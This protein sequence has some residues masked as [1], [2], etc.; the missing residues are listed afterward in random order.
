MTDPPV[1][2]LRMAQCSSF[3]LAVFG[4][5]AVGCSS[6]TLREEQ[7]KPTVVDFNSCEVGKLPPDFTTALTG[8]GG[9]VSWVVRKCAGTGGKK[10]NSG[11]GAAINYLCKHWRQL[12]LF[13]QKA[14]VPQII[15]SASGH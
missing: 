2:P 11:L 6:S 13:L 14:G 10:P 4:G 1:E 9:P 3:F 5:H 7:I 15:T 8:G 12:T